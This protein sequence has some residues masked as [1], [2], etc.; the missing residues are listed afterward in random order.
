MIRAIPRFQIATGWV[1]CAQRW[2]GDVGGERD[3]FSDADAPALI[4]FTSGSTG[5]P[6]AAARTHRFLLAWATA[7]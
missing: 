5:E 3:A 4:T 1:P 6:K 2:Q 7:L